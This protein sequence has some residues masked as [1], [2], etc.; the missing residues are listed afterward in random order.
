MD[1]N[2]YKKYAQMI[3]DLLQ[4]EKLNDYCNLTTSERNDFTDTILDGLQKQTPLKP[5]TNPSHRY[6]CQSCGII[7]HYGMNH[8]DECGQK[9]LWE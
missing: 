7:L 6:V 2:K 3:V 4:F 9:L 1:Y 5:L 8:C